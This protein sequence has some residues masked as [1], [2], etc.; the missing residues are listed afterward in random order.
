MQESKEGVKM[1][2][3]WTIHRK[4]RSDVLTL[5]TSACAA[6][7]LGTAYHQALQFHQDEF[8]PSDEATWLKEKST[9]SDVTAILA[10]A[11]EKYAASKAK[12]PKL[13]AHFTSWWQ[14]AS[15]SLMRYEK[16]IDTF[17]SSHPEY[18]ALLWGAMKFLF[19][20]R[21]SSNSYLDVFNSMINN[22]IPLDYLQLSANVSRDCE[23]L[24]KDRAGT[25][26][27]QFHRIYTLSH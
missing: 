4:D 27:N 19:T 26:R 6:Q 8:G 5:F 13:L 24:C 14:A 3:S 20:V 17:V 12:K 21:F 7:V 2:E 11:E 9:L 23:V 25:A 22:M 18:S 16:V 1:S 10:Q 15:S